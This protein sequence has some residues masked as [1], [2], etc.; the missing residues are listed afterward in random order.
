M[1]LSQEGPRKVSSPRIASAKRRSR[2]EKEPEKEKT[3]ALAWHDRVTDQVLGRSACGMAKEDLGGAQCVQDRTPSV[4]GRE[5]NFQPSLRA[6]SKR[7]LFVHESL[8]LAKEVEHAEKSGKAEDAHALLEAFQAAVHS[9]SDLAQAERAH[10]LGAALCAST[11]LS[12]FAQHAERRRAAARADAAARERWRKRRVP[13]EMYVSNAIGS[14]ASRMHSTSQTH[15]HPDDHR[16]RDA[17]GNSSP[18]QQS[19]QLLQEQWQLQEEQQLLAQELGPLVDNVREVEGR[20]EEVSALS[21]A[22]SGHIAKQSEQIE[23]LY[24]EA[25]NAS[26]KLA[27]GNSAL[28]QA[29]ERTTSSRHHTFYVLLALSVALLLLD[30]VS[31]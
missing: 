24:S 30:A 6:A 18:Q 1:S 2:C 7:T 13:P 3:P 9:A 17:R 15:S 27:Q 21:D 14:A 16:H 11:R 10:L 5:A 19:Q 4:L 22:L 23:H 8:N 25:I 12:S 20:V 26:G 31:P 29:V 28:S